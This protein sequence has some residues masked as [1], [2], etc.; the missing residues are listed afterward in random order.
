MYRIGHT[1]TLNEKQQREVRIHAKERT[2][3]N[4][5]CNV[6]SKTTPE[7]DFEIDLQGFGGEYAFCLMF[8]LTPDTTIY[9]RSG[10]MDKGDCVL[11]G[12]NIDVKT[13][14]RSD[15]YLLAPISKMNADIYA[16]ALMVGK[17]PTYTF[18]GFMTHDEIF[19]PERRVT[20]Y[21]K[22]FGIGYQQELT[23]FDALWLYE[24]IGGREFRGYKINHKALAAG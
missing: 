3:N 19:L 15:G 13:R 23:E 16:F 22:E 14:S 2:L 12:K 21:D 11:E 10:K 9:P 7:R 4:R 8:G 6:Q 20:M 17:F 24:G 18:K 1:I 5:R